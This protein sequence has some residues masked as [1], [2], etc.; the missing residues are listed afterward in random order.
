M[1]DTRSFRIINMNDTIIGNL[2][3]DEENAVADLNATEK[4]QTG[5]DYLTLA[6]SL[7]WIFLVFFVIIVIGTLVNISI[8]VTLLRSRRNGKC[9]SMYFITSH[10]CLLIVNFFTRSCLLIIIII[11]RMF[12]FIIRTFYAFP[13]YVY[14]SFN[15]WL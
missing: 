12:L 15:E 8:I 3:A 5:E 14:L 4:I 9:P 10:Q 2:T 11:I 13:T 6:S 1:K 7:N